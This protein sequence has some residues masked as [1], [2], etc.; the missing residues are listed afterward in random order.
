MN[1][2]RREPQTDVVREALEPD[3][4]Q[5]RER[6]DP[7]RQRDHGSLLDEDLAGSRLTRDPRGEVDGLSVHIA[8]ADDNKPCGDPSMSRRQSGRL[9]VRDE[10]QD[11]SDR[12]GGTAEAQQHAI[13]EEL[14]DPPT[15]V[16]HCPV[17]E[18]LES[19]RHLGRGR[20]AAFD[21]QR[22]E[23]RQV[24]ERDRRR[25][26]RP[27]LKTAGAYKCILDPVDDPAI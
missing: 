6:R 13:A 27:R 16:S 7:G 17:G 11:R 22:R 8:V 21:G 18:S 4:P 19:S 20:V 24:D 12:V 3:P 1:G 25:R 15:G 10:P 26:F 9:D 5:R 14:D 2:R 23:A